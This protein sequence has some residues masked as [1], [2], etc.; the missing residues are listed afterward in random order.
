MQLVL[1]LEEESAKALLQALLPRLFPGQE[2]RYVVFEGKQDLEKQL[3]KRL[4]GWQA[5]EACRF[6]VLRDKD[7]SDCHLTKERLQALCRA[8]GKEGVLVRIACRELESWYLGDLKAVEGALGSDSV[9]ARQS[10]RKYR[11]PDRLENPL[12]ELVRLVPT[13]QKIAGSR[14][15]GQCMELQN[16]TS[17]SFNVFMEGIRRLLADV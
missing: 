14:A 3:S 13:Y 10:G 12:Q 7:A 2:F 5:P 9:A 17:R 4:R 15:M 1:F 16:N 6:V 8:G 11:D